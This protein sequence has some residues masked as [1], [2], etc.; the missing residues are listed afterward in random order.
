[1][2][3]Y[4]QGQD[5]KRGARNN[6]QGNDHYSVASCYF[7]F[8]SVLAALLDVKKEPLFILM[9]EGK[10]CSWRSATRNLEINGK[11]K[12]SVVNK[13]HF[14]YATSMKFGN[15]FRLLYSSGLLSIKLHN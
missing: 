12:M 3:C 7:L 11:R 8:V 5:L 1:V 14:W 15:F 6:V 10:L 13:K 4:E 9:A 2:V